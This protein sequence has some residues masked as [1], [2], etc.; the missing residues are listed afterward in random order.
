MQNLYAILGLSPSAT[1][2]EV[3]SAFRRRAREVHPDAHGD[4]AQFVALKDAYAILG[5]ATKRAHYDAERH[6]WMK[7]VGAV[8]CP[9]CG[10]ANRI[11]H[12]PAAGQ[13]VR[14]WHCKTQL[15]VAAASLLDAQRQA[16]LNEA[17]RVAQDVGVDLAE[18]AGDA[19]RAGIAHLRQRLD[20]HRQ[21][22]LK[23]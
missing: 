20:L 22:K 19:L 9:V 18:L 16:L 1:A 3:K 21:Q 10:H 15:A 11:T 17:A 12:R 6:A 14:C 5:D 8:A 4:S 7:R 23:G 2:D 13:R